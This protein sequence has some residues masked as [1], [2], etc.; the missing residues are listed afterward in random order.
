MFLSHPFFPIQIQNRRR[1]TRT[2]SPGK[3]CGTSSCRSWPLRGKEE[4]SSGVFFFCCFGTRR[5]GGEEPPKEKEKKTHSF[6]PPKL[7]KP[8]ENKNS[9]APDASL[10]TYVGDAAGRLGDFADSD[11]GFAEAAGLRFQTPEE[12]FGGPSDVNEFD[13]GWK[14]VIGNVEDDDDDEEEEE[15]GGGNGGDGGAGPGSS[16]G[17]VKA[18][19]GA[20]A[21]GGGGGGGEKPKKA[22]K[23]ESPNAPILAFFSKLCD[24][25]KADAAARGEE[26]KKNLGFKL[27]AA[28]KAAASFR[29]LAVEVT[30]VEQVKALVKAKELPGVGKASVERLQAWFE[31]G[32]CDMFAALEAQRAALADRVGSAVA[33]GVAAVSSPKEEEAKPAVASPAAAAAAAPPPKEEPEENYGALAFA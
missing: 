21:G 9:S 22:K 23:K 7:K 13:S 31:T 17:G 15:E 33:A 24:A 18:E 2:G 4:R 29:A 28:A 27:S 26:G 20:A 6:F 19:G 14:G 1:T 30:S 12:F 8:F 32:T 10:S 16:G 11:K 5:G 3:A 25:Y